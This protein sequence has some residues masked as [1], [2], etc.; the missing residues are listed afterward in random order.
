MAQ[1]L[2]E[3]FG[4]PNEGIH[5]HRLGPFASVDLGVTV[6][7]AII[8][9]KIFNKSI[10]EVFIWLFIIG[11]IAHGFFGVNTGFIQLIGGQI[12]FR[13]IVVSGI[14]G[15][16]IGLACGW[17]PVITSILTIIISLLF[18]L[19]VFDKN[20]KKIMRFFMSP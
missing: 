8:I 1:N 17:N 7:V 9:A 11:Q 18:S 15:W 3:I 16:I 12:R 2:S 6:L 5:S 19:L 20:T 4:K 10:I 13:D 14:I